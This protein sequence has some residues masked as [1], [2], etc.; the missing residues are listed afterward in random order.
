VEYCFEELEIPGYGS[1]M[2]L[3]GTATLSDNGDG[4]FCLDRIDLDGGRRLSRPNV[5]NGDIDAFLFREIEALFY[6]DQTTIGRYAQI[7]WEDYL[8]ERN[9]PDAD[10]ARDL[11]LESRGERV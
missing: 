10:Y 7:E 1:G 2:L 5:H 4:Q 8:A 6:N 3:Y 11:W 9:E